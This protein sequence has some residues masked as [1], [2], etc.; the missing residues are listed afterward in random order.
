VSTQINLAEGSQNMNSSSLFVMLAAL[1]S[2]GCGSEISGSPI[3]SDGG[4]SIDSMAPQSDS[5]TVRASC[6]KSEL[7][8]ANPL[9]GIQGEAWVIAAYP[10]TNPAA[11][12]RSDY[13]GGNKTLDG[14][15]GVAFE[16]ANFRDM[17]QG[18]T[19][20]AV[21]S[22]V[23]E[24]ID[25]SFDDRNV[26]PVGVCT[27]SVTSSN[28]LFL[29]HEN[30]FLSMYSQL[31]ESSIPLAVGDSVSSGQ[32]VGVVGSSGCAT[33]PGVLFRLKGCAY[34]I[35][36]GNVDDSDGMDPFD[37]GMWAAEPSYTLPTKLMD[38][39]VRSS[40][41]ADVLDALDPLANAPSVALGEDFGWALYWSHSQSQTVHLN[42]Y[43]PDNTFS[44]SLSRTLVPSQRWI[45]WGSVNIG[46]TA[47]PWRAEVLLEGIKVHEFTVLVQ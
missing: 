2:L 29:R 40:V 33:R 41:Y 18:M 21:A 46:T 36:L 15:T 13:M 42:W 23:V 27:D 35:D 22:G 6:D 31:K 3:S 1:L 34:D 43:R 19:V 4:G 30:G 26:G 9:L 14:F 17:D 20:H 12:G 16:V 47:G 45:N 44:F 24:F 28:R 32:I 5:G 25:D 38:T 8:L 10:D 7:T 11:I 37:E 39:A